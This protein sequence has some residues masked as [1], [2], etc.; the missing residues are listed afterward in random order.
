VQLVFFLLNDSVA[1]MKIEI[2]CR[3]SP[4]PEALAMLSAAE[5]AEGIAFGSWLDVFNAGPLSLLGEGGGVGYPL[6]AAFEAFMT[7]K[8][9]SKPLLFGRSHWYVIGRED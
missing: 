3:W 9:F 4:P 1:A 8:K 7:L 6:G 2:S 5:F